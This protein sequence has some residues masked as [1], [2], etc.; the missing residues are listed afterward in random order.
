MI[1]SLLGSI[2]YFI[3]I[4]LAGTSFSSS[5]RISVL[6]AAVAPLN[7]MSCST[8]E[9]LQMVHSISTIQIQSLIRVDF[10]WPI[11]FTSDTIMQGVS[12]TWPN[13]CMG[14]QISNWRTC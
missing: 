3:P 6:T 7:I 1:H 8:V 12:Q 2:E 14:F 10:S 5:E 4:H 13:F 9:L 11:S